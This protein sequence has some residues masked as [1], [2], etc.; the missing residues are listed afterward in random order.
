MSR[1][2]NDRSRVKLH[3][4]ATRAGVSTMTVSN[5]I[6]RT[7]RASPDTGERVLS[8]IGELGYVPNQSARK[9]TGSGVACVGLEPGETRT[10]HFTRRLED[11]TYW[12]A[13]TRSFVQDATTFDV[14]LGDSSTASLAVSFS[15]D[16]HRTSVWSRYFSP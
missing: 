2:R 11:L 13:S 15:P 8:A 9:L 1:R 3:A 12:A 5:V 4:V 10:V 14:Y 16:P 7:G 6:N